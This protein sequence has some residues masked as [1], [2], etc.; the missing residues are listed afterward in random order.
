DGRAETRITHRPQRRHDPGHSGRFH[1]TR[2]PRAV[3]IP[4]IATTETSR[5]MSSPALL[6]RALKPA[7]KLGAVAVL[8]TL[9]GSIAV[10]AAHAGPEHFSASLSYSASTVNLGGKIRAT[11]TLMS[12]LPAGV[13]ESAAVTAMLPQYLTLAANYGD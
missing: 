7:A 1:G 9:L 13:S 4:E 11:I 2:C 12:A 3:A 8:A 6:R 10:P 5:P